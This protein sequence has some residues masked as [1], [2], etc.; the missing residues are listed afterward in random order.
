MINQ[1]KRRE[2]VPGVMKE[3]KKTGI[4][5]I[6]IQDKGRTVNPKILPLLA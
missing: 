5:L 3:I 4:A 1:Y 6:F 2:C